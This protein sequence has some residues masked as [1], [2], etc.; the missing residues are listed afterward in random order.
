MLERGSTLSLME[1]IDSRR[2]LW[3]SVSA[4]MRHHW[5]RE[6]L[7]RLSREAGIGLATCAR[8]KAQETSVGL[9]LIDRIAAVF[10]VETWQLFVPGFDPTSPPVLLPVSQ[11]ERELYTRLLQAAKAFKAPLS[12]STFPPVRGWGKQNCNSRSESGCVP[13]PNAA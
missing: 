3:A 9:E 6:N 4:L 13:I 12:R 2:V 11:Q 1:A 7:N 8:I 5:E 10:S